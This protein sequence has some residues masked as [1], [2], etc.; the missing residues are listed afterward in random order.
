MDTLQPEGGVRHEGRRRRGG[1]LVDESG[2]DFLPI[3]AE[4]QHRQ[5]KQ[6]IM[7]QQV[8]VLLAF[9]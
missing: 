8:G 9:R 2:I 1:G 5:W 3:P 7:M 4:R 6:G